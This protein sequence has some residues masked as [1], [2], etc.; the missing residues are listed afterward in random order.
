MNNQS[1][2]LESSL[3]SLLVEESG[4][5]A[6]KDMNK[7]R[8]RDYLKEQIDLMKISISKIDIFNLRQGPYTS[9]VLSKIQICKESLERNEEQIYP[10]SLLKMQKMLNRLELTVSKKNAYGKKIDRYLERKDDSIIESI[11]S[12]LLELDLA[13]FERIRVKLIGYKARLEEIAEKLDK[14]LKS[15]KL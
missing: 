3:N 13:S 11:K 1:N 10:N 8:T 15:A 12:N 6:T 9:T 14:E 7:A 2:L 4:K 5:M